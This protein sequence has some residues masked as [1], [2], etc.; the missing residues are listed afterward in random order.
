[1]II[2][3]TLF[4]RIFCPGNNEFYRISSIKSG[5]YWSRNS[6]LNINI[7]SCINYL[8]PISVANRIIFWIKQINL[9]VSLTISSNYCKNFSLINFHETKHCLEMAKTHVI[10]RKNMRGLNKIIRSSKFINFTKIN[11]SR[12]YDD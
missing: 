3:I 11:K 10:F 5:N 6:T 12:K 1:M 8:K 4:W 7:F 2:L 9:Y